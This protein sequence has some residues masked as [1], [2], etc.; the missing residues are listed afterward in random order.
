MKKRSRLLSALLTLVMLLSLVPALGTTAMAYD[1]IKLYLHI[2]DNAFDAPEVKAA[3]SEMTNGKATGLGIYKSGKITSGPYYDIGD[4]YWYAVRSSSTDEDI[5]SNKG[6]AKSPGEVAITID[7]IYGQSCGIASDTKLKDRFVM[8]V[9]VI[10]DPI[11]HVDIDGVKI[12]KIGASMD[13]G[14]YGSPDDTGVT[15]STEGAEVVETVWLEVN[16]G[17]TRICDYNETFG[18]NLYYADI[19]V[20][21]SH[22]YLFEGPWDMSAN[23]NGL[24][25]RDVL[26]VESED[27]W[28]RV[29]ASFDL[30]NGD[31]EVDNVSIT[32]LDAPTHGKAADYTASANH[33]D[34]QVGTIQY[35]MFNKVLDSYVGSK[36]DNITI[37]VNVLAQNGYLFPEKPTAIWNG[38]PSVSA[39]LSSAR[40]F[41]TFAFPYSVGAEDSAILK[42]L[43]FTVAAP[44]IGKAP[45]AS[46][47][48]PQGVTVESVAWTPA[49]TAFK[50]GVS[51]TVKIGFRADSTHIL[52]DD[53][54]NTGT[55]TINDQSTQLTKPTTG[56]I[57]DKFLTTC[58]A[59][60]TF[61]PLRAEEQPVSPDQPN[62]FTDVKE[63]DYFY[64]PVLW[65][66]EKEITNGTSATTF[67]PANTCTRAQIITFLWRASGSPEP[68][69]TCSFLDVP[70]GSY[71]EK[72]VVWATEQGMVEGDK[73]YPNDPCTRLMAVEFMW[74]QSGKPGAP[75]ASFTDVNS[76][77]VDWAVEAGVTNG[78]SA[79]TFSPDSTCTRGQ[80]VTFLWR[81]FG[82]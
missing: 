1:D 73:F 49:D 28:L 22:C 7:K 37:K 57:K 69:I 10:S 30:R 54:L 70:A 56:G 61:L 58:Y 48:A 71:Y 67:S 40:N 24:M 65:A 79:T 23:V 21:P 16:N 72:A 3:I 26:G 19:Y 44:A 76:P 32:G 75:A 18:K 64:S 39:E 53:F 74:I 8:K 55:V 34:F 63:S 47:T 46:V 81:A 13:D 80:I 20:K 33:P 42:N 82:K 27:G 68:G 78:T 12:P 38:I 35:T 29:R 52:A 17:T 50:E 4:N 45:A 5:V 60:Y 9:Y 43:S 11:Y 6:L 62:P 25:C 14:Y 77:A 51:Y 41:C 2:G 15:T 66:V 36:G 59:S 31:L